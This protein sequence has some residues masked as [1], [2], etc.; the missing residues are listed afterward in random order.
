LTAR[1]S[2][3]ERSEERQRASAEVE[4]LRRESDHRR[5]V[6]ESDARLLKE[7]AISRAT[8]DSDEP[9]L[10][11]AQERLPEAQALLDSLKGPEGGRVELSAETAH[12]LQRR[13]ALLT[14]RAPADGIV[15]GLPRKAGETVAAGQ[16]VASVA[17]P[18]H[19][20]V[21]TRVDEPDLPRIAVGQRM[22]VTFDG[23]P[24][25]RWE[26]KGFRSSGVTETGRPA[27]G[28]SRGRDLRHP[29]TLPPNASVNV[30]IIVGES[31]LP[32]HPARRAP[33]RRQRYVYVLEKGRA[34][35]RRSPSV[36]SG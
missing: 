7:S 25:R 19:L 16:I 4:R 14:I 10:A 29:A 30:Q 13:V 1:S 32:L 11:H 28:R 2:A 34:R 35:R 33:R 23:L 26:G 22:I 18:E 17:D 21:R 24:D 12:E 31:A 20:R 9:R 5:Q 15:Y 27:G 36:W 6:F 8:H 3:L